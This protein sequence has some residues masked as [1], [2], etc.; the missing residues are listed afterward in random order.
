MRNTISFRINVLL[1]ADRLGTS[2]ITIRIDLSETRRTNI[3]NAIAIKTIE[4][5]EDLLGI[6]QFC[7]NVLGNEFRNTESAIPNVIVLA[8]GLGLNT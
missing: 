5:F 1:W 3:E 7:I 6:V 4:V 8:S 2:R